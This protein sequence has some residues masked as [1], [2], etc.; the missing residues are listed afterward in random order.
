[1]I[2]DLSASADIRT[3]AA[4]GL[5]VPREAITEAS[6]KPVVYVRQEGGFAAREVA[7]GGE[8]PTQV[9]V[10]GGLQEGEE[11]AIDPHSVINP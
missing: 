3:S 1:V 6:G 7:I 2:P 4:E 9:A 5:I 10:T 11:I 8:S